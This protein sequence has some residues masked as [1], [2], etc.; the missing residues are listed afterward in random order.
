MLLLVAGCTT[1]GSGS[2]SGS[3]SRSRSRSGSGSSGK[4]IG[5]IS[6]VLLGL[7]RFLGDSEFSSLDFDLRSPFNVSRLVGALDLGCD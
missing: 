6:N 2:G 3:R 5:S 1:I 4:M 7:L